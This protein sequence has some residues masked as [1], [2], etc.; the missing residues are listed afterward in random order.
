MLNS[1][2]DLIFASIGDRTGEL[3][4]KIQ[5][6]SQRAKNNDPNWVCFIPEFCYRVSFIKNRIILP[7]TN[8]DIYVLPKTAI[9]P[10]PELT[11]RFLN[12][13]LDSAKR[14]QENLFPGG[15]VNILG[16]SLGNVLAFRFAE[17]YQTNKL[18]SVVP[19]SRLADCIWE[20]IATN[21]IARG[22]GRTLQE[23][24]Q[25]LKLFDPISSVPRI[26][27]AYAEIFLGLHDLIIPYGRGEELAK[28]METKFRIKKYL[29]KTSGHVETV[30]HFSKHF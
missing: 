25:I 20:S 26:T 10:D 23:Y 19:G 14:Q 7:G 28:A 21:K 29:Y 6:H 9:Q 13:I 5:H 27:P 24:R 8:M 18:I 1:F 4:S 30:I 15:K 12:D 17:H 16:I 2:L 11:D 22:S 3:P